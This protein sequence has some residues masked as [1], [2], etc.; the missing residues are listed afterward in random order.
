MELFLLALIAA[1]AATEKTSPKLPFLPGME[2]PREPDESERRALVFWNYVLPP[3]IRSKW[4]R[5]QEKNATVMFWTPQQEAAF[6]MDTLMCPEGHNALDPLADMRYSH[7]IE[8]FETPFEPGQSPKAM[9]PEVN[10][11][12]Y[13]SSDASPDKVAGVLWCKHPE[14]R[15]PRGTVLPFYVVQALERSWQ[16]DRDVLR[17]VNCGW[18]GTADELGRQFYDVHHVFEY[19]S[20]G[21]V[22]FIGECPECESL[23]YPKV[24][25]DPLP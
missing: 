14:H 16:S 25:V 21:D 18:T 8:V 12:L 10:S 15:G 17:C 22:V 4:S 20:P 5:L 24:H 1:I 3:S 2:P 13:D 11:T 23:V 7:R 6:L 9:V 19:L